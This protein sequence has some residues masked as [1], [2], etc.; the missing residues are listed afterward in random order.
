M[1]NSESGVMPGQK[2]YVSPEGIIRSTDG[3][4]RWVCRLNRWADTTKL[5]AKLKK[6]ICVGAILGII[7]VLSDFGV[8]LSAGLSAALRFVPAFAACGALLALL[9]H[10]ADSLS[11]GGTCCVLFTMDETMVRRQQVKGKADRDAVAHTVAVWTGGQSQPSLRF[12]EPIES[13]FDSI[14]TIVP[15]R[16][17]NL[18]RIKS[19]AG[20]NRICVEPGQFDVVLDWLGQHCPQAEIK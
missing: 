2:A 1:L 12:E 13:R 18:L 16:G 4:L 6:Y 8:G 20:V 17:R 7:P 14:K 10:G 15:D 3:K 19:R 5:A 9:R 11:N